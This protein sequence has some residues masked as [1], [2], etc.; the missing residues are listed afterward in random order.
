LSYEFVPERKK[1]DYPPRIQAIANEYERH[2]FNYTGPTIDNDIESWKEMGF[3]R[4]ARVRPDTVYLDVIAV[5]RIFDEYSNKEFLIW[6]IKKHVRDRDDKDYNVE[7]WM[8]KRPRFDVEP[9]L[10][11]DGNEVDKRI[12]RWNMVYTQEWDKDVFQKIVD[13]SKSK[14]IPLYIAYSSDEYHT[15]HTGQSIRIKD[16]DIFKNSAT[17]EQLRKYDKKLEQD[18]LLQTAYAGNKK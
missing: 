1:I 4:R 5:Y 3:E 2:G 16:I 13:E 9:V 11:D 7:I 12:T 18:R 14:R 17:H 8:G 15:T 6:K 10:D